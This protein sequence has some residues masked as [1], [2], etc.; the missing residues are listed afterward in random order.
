MTTLRCLFSPP[1]A[2]THP[3][4][5]RAI[6]VDSSRLATPVILSPAPGSPATKGD[7]TNL[8]KFYATESEEEETEDDEEDDSGEEAEESDEE[9]KGE[10]GGENEDEERSED[11]ETKLHLPA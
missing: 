10:S 11:E 6:A 7:W 9:G 4:F 5:P 3:P 2:Q 1:S 8:D